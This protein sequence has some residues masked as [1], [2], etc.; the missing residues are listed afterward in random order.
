MTERDP[1][2]VIVAVS[3]EDIVRAA[4]VAG[5]MVGEYEM[6][7]LQHAMATQ[8]DLRAFVHAMGRIGIRKAIAEAYDRRFPY[9]PDHDFDAWANGEG[10]YALTLPAHGR[11][12]DEFD[13][14]E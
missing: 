3:D 7:C 1:R 13:H 12:R 10:Y 9:R 4:A 2:S 5:F 14:D 8:D 11:D 6:G